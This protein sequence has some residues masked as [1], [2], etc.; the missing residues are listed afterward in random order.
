MLWAAFHV[1][2]EDADKL[3]QSLVAAAMTYGGKTK[4]VVLRPQQDRFA[5]FPA[6]LERFNDNGNIGQAAGRLRQAMPELEHQAAIDIH[7][8]SEHLHAAFTDSC[9]GAA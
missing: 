6:E 4:W 2:P 1:H 9:S 8:L 7:R 5:L 3:F